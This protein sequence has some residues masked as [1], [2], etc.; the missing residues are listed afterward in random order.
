MGRGT[1]APFLTLSRA[2]PLPPD[3]SRV[4]EWY[5]G[6]PTQAALHTWLSENQDRLVWDRASGTYHF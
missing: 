1:M 6:S 4:G 3:L 5:A 2:L